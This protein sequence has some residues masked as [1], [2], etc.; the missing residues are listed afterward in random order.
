MFYGRQRA[1]DLMMRSA[2]D[3]YDDTELMDTARL[4]PMS[5]QRLEEL[6]KLDDTWYVYTYIHTYIYE[7]MNT[8]RL[9]PMSEQIYRDRDH[10][11]AE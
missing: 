2:G 11:R 4:E 1:M 6:R 3:R 10:D 8:V 9:E 7:L 5:E